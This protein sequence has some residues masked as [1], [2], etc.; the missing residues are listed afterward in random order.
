MPELALAPVE[1]PAPA[2]ATP[3]EA[4]TKAREEAEEAATPDIDAIAR[5]VYTILKRRL[6]REREQALGAR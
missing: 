1:Q 4:E 2:A 3:P 6:V 5:D